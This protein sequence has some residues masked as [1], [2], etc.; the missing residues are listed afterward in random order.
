MADRLEAA[1]RA[2]EGLALLGVLEGAVEDAL[3]ARDAAD[4]GDEPL[5]LE[6][7]GDVVEALALLAEQVLRGDADVLEGELAGVGGVH[8]HLLQLAGDAEALDLLARRSPGCR[9]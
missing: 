7:P 3:R 2:A 1:D 8:P 6:L 4:R 5:P 9:R